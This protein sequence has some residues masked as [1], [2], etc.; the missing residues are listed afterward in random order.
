MRRIVLLSTMLALIFGM[1]S[2]SWAQTATGQIMGTIKDA[3]GAVMAGA[4]V[5][6]SNEQTGLTRETTTSDTG[7]YVFPL[8]PTGVYSVSAEQQ[9]FIRWPNSPTLRSSSIRSC[10]S[11]WNW[12]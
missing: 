8:L 11:I 12:R 3:S 9:G 2:R 7:D 4:K 10:V 1:V 5:K 6:I